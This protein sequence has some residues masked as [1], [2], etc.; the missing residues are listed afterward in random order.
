M[1]F[2]S[3]PHD[4]GTNDCNDYLRK[5]LNKQ[6]RFT[7]AAEIAKQLGDSARIRIFWI[8]CHYEECV[9]NISALMEMSSPAV[10]H[11]LRILKDNGLIE[12]RREGK[13][14]YY[15]ARD[16]EI[17]RLLHQMIEEVMEIACPEKDSESSASSPAE[18]V[19]KVHHYLLEHM[20]EHRM[21][22]AA[23]MLLETDKSIA[24]VAKAVGYES[25]S[26]FTAAFQKYYNTAPLKY[27]NQQ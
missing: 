1:E 2:I 11:H 18:T 26:K 13:E 7:V 14:V 15:K 9:I 4:H 12:S 24:E 16:T 22:H 17:C 6:D 3:L 27:K 25:Q 21:K 20:N 10:S 8:L 5:E 19:K 23:R